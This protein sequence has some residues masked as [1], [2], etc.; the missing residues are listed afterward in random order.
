MTKFIT[1]NNLWYRLQQ[2]II[3]VL[4]LILLKW[5][6]YTLSNSGSLTITQVFYHFIGMSIMGA[7]LIRGCAF[8]ARYHYLKE[9]K[10]KHLHKNQTNNQNKS[11]TP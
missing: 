10:A 11:Q 6:Y 3:F 7:V 8:W 1:T 4:H 2:L 5:M 9:E